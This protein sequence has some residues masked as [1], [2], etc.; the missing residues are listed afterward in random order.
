MANKVKQPSIVF[1]QTATGR[2]IPVANNMNAVLAPATADEYYAKASSLP[3]A[4]G[5]PEWTN[6]FENA[7]G[8]KVFWTIYP[9]CKS[10]RKI[11]MT[12]TKIYLQSNSGDIMLVTAELTDR[13]WLSEDDAFGAL[14]QEQLKE[15]N[16]DIDGMIEC[17]H[18]LKELLK[19]L[20]E[21]ID[22]AIAERNDLSDAFASL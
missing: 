22:K 8:G 19:M 13:V 15:L 4:E 16:A 1:A 18:K 10:P 7:A 12:E 20:N 2:V 17:R 9:S 14:Y 5:E 6:A 3:G 11:V 21:D